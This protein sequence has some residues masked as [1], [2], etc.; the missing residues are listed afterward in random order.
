MPVPWASG[1]HGLDLFPVV[2]Y[3]PGHPAPPTPGAL[4]TMNES[5][6]VWRRTEESCHPRTPPPFLYPT[7]CD[8]V[9]VKK[10]IF[11]MLVWLECV[12]SRSDGGGGM[13]APPRPWPT[14]E[15]MGASAPAAQ[16]KK[17]SGGFVDTHRCGRRVPTANPSLP[18]WQPLRHSVPPPTTEPHNH[19]PPSTFRPSAPPHPQPH[20]GGPGGRWSISPLRVGSRATVST[21]RYRPLGS[22]QSDM[23]DP[24]STR[25][26]STLNGV[27]GHTPDPGPRELVPRDRDS[28][29]GLALA[30]GG[31][32]GLLIGQTGVADPSRP[33]GGHIGG[34]T[35]LGWKHLQGAPI[36]PH[37]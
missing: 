15:G 22:R 6:V 16:E 10:I 29:R 26:C 11:L 36:Q 20:H 33:R 31:G 5:S 37:S 17:C 32:R 2:S 12:L 9:C 28:S 7:S 18:H 27:R 23:C 8:C 4:S 25:P 34:S 30:G 14:T 21:A 13:A 24:T 35:W 19:P 1:H 3:G